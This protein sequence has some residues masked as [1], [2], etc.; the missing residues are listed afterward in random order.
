MTG[1]EQQNVDRQLRRSLGS[2]PAALAAMFAA[3]GLD[4]LHIDE[5]VLRTTDLHEPCLLHNLDF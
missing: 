2:A 1:W 3:A 5:R 4:A